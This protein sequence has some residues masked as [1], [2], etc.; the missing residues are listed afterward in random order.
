MSAITQEQLAELLNTSAAQSR[1]ALWIEPLNQAMTEWAINTV[2]RQ[3]AFLAQ[4][5]HESGQFKSLVENLHYSALRLRQIWPQRFPTD[6]IAVQYASNP[7][8]LANKIYAGR[9]G[10]GDEA[11][12]DGWKYRGRGLIQLTGRDNYQRCEKALKLDLLTHPELLQEPAGAARSAAWFWAEAKLN[13]LADPKPNGDAHEDFVKICHRINGGS[14]GLQARIDCWEKTK[15][16]LA[17]A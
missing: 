11:S 14:V 15:R 12:G 5:L 3:A 6:T 1:A 9:L 10:N 7:E 4:V 16:V 13:A 8:K 17:T 2:P